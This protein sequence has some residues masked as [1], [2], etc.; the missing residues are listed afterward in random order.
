MQTSLLG[1]KQC[2]FFCVVLLLCLLSFPVVGRAEDR[3]C[4]RETCFTVEVV[5]TRETRQRGLQE[6]YDLP[7]DAGMFFVFPESAYYSFW[8][9]KTFIPLDIIWIG[10]SLRVV[11]IEQHCQPCRKDPCPIF[12]PAAKALYV[13]EIPAG[14]AQK[15][16][17]FLQDVVRL[18]LATDFLSETS[19]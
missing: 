17:F 10:E 4:I 9:R 15:Y 1:F 2:S 8:M 14:Q 5:A 3:V 12:S 13:L 7:E 19:E 11:H 6:R 18:D 16:G